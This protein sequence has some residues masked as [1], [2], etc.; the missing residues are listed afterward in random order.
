MSSLSVLGAGAWPAVAAAG[1]AGAVLRHVV[2]QLLARRTGGPLTGILTVNLAGSLALGVLVGGGL[3]HG[4]SP[5]WS[6][7]LGT[8][9]CGGLTT[10]STV[11]VASAALTRDRDV[12]RALA[13][14][15]GTLLATVALSGAGV[16]VMALA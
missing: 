10:F 13:N 2:D 9:F 4:W 15:V 7:V 8:G 14:A 5:W 12:R 11:A 16:A 3:F 6:A 1:A